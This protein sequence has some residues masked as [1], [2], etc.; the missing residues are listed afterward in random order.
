[1]S[2][3][4]PSNSKIVIFEKHCKIT[5]RT[6]SL[7]QVSEIEEATMHTHTHTHS[8]IHMCVCGGGR[9]SFIKSDRQGFGVF[10]G[11]FQLAIEITQLLMKAV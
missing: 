6:F 9:F 10:V 1:M 5:K 4:N 7:C 2:F 3:F 11:L 8:C